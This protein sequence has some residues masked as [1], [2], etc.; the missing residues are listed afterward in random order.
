MRAIDSGAWSMDAMG[1][2]GVCFPV[3][4]IEA[5]EN[6]ELVRGLG[7]MGLMFPGLGEKEEGRMK[8]GD[9]TD[10]IVSSSF[11]CFPSFSS[12]LHSDSLEGEDG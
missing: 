9:C 8:L 5:E 6:G 7:D 11:I 3:L 1:M 2:D 12:E 10:A 4:V